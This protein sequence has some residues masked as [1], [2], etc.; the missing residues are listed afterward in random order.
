M[1]KLIPNAFLT[2]KEIGI[3]NVIDEGEKKKEI[4]I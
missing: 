3:K 2:I 1:V 4:A